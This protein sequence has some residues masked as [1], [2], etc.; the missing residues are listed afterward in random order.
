M[1]QLMIRF[2]MGL[3]SK[4]RKIVSPFNPPRPVPALLCDRRH[5]TPVS[6]RPTEPALPHHLPT[7]LS[8][9]IPICDNERDCGS[10]RTILNHSDH[11]T[12]ETSFIALVGHP[13]DHHVQLHIA[14]EGHCA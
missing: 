14:S 1:S 10:C 6:T 11:P 5:V 2:V 4:W 8:V 7:L 12:H 3:R 9:I 13:T